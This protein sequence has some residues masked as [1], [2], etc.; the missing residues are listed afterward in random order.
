MNSQLLLM[1]EIN[2]LKKS[3]FNGETI[4]KL[5]FL[6]EDE[7]KGISI[8][9]VKLQPTQDITNLARGTKVQ[10]PITISAMDRN[11]FYKQRGKIVIK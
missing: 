4:H 9:E 8:I 6:Q 2:F 10:V 7:T 5:Q 3:E 11:V 1:G